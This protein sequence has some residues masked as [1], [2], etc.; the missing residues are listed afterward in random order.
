MKRYAKIDHR[1]GEVTASHPDLRQPVVGERDLPVHVF[2][3]KDS[4]N[5]D[6]GL[7][8]GAVKP[9]VEPG[10]GDRFFDVPAVGADDGRGAAVLNEPFDDLGIESGIKG[11]LHSVQVHPQALDRVNE[12]GESFRAQFRVVNI[13]RTD[14]GKPKHESL[15]FRYRNLFFPLLMLVSRVPDS[16]PPFLTTVLEPSP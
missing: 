10:N 12:S 15:V 9:T 4:F 14:A 2:P 1:S 6:A 16:C 7:V 11:D 3:C 5:D 8:R 13:D